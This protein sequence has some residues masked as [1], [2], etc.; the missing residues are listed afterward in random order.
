MKN[1]KRQET[2]TEQTRQRRETL[3]VIWNFV[4]ETKGEKNLNGN[5]CE[6]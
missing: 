6:K 2:A 1:N 3:T 5:I 4:S